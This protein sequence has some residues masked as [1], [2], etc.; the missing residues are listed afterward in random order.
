MKVLTAIAVLTFSGAGFAKKPASASPAPASPT[1]KTNVNYYYWYS[2]FDGSYNDD[3]TLAWE[4]WEMEIYY[5][6]SNVNTDQVGG[7]LIEKGYTINNPGFPANVF[8]Y[9]HFD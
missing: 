9:A 3:E 1:A 8:L 6:C 7:T 5:D 4:E 2:A